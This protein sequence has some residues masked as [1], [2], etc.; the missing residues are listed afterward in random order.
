MSLK[1]EAHFNIKCP[2]CSE[3][4]T[5]SYPNGDIKM[6]AKVFVWSKEG[7]IAVCKSCTA[8]VSINFDILKSI[9][10]KFTYEVSK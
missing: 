1:N 8:D 6:R 2:K 9:Q 5:K 7:L 10:T 3:Q 4:I